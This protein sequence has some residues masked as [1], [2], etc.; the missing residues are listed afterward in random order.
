MPGRGGLSVAGVV[1]GADR[2]DDM[3][4]LRAGA[5][6]IVLDRPY[7]LWM[8][9]PLDITPTAHRWITVFDRPRPRLLTE[10]I[11]PPPRSWHTRGRSAHFSHGFFKYR[12]PRGSASVGMS[13]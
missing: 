4:L 6:G 3:G 12:A 11:T 7:T 13:N 5:M 9:G 1:A 2:I 8:R 10:R